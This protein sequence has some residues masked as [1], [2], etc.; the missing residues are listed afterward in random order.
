LLFPCKYPLFSISVFE[1]LTSSAVVFVV[2]SLLHP[3]LADTSLLD[4]RDASRV[5]TSCGCF[6]VNA[7]DGHSKPSYFHNYTFLDFSDL[8]SFVRDPSLID[9]LQDHGNEPATSSFFTHSNFTDRFSVQ[10]WTQAKSKK[11]PDVSTID[12]VN[13][14]QNI[15]ISMAFRIYS[16]LFPR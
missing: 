9:S 4:G 13:S 1:M 3:V 12:L 7:T 10:N 15:Y 14:P 11:D 5:A 2:L 6:R 8:D 16:R